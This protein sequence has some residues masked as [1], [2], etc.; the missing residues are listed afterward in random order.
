MARV[1]ERLFGH[2]KLA[3][4]RDDPYLQV[5]SRAI[6]DGRDPAALNWVALDLAALVCKQQE[7]LCTAC[8]LQIKYKLG[9]TRLMMASGKASFD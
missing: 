1:I 7:P 2:R 9:R 6:V 4:I 5:L 3:D 8:P